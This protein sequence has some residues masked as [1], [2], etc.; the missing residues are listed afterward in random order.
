MAKEFTRSFEVRWSE[1]GAANRVPASKYMEYLVETAYD[2][3]AENRLGFEE[4]QILGLVWLILETDIH[5]LHP[6]RFGD[7]FDFTIWMLDWR[8]ISGTRAFELR[9]KDS[10]KIVAHGMQ[11][12]VSLDDESLRPKAV[13]VE[14]I[15]G[16]RMEA[17][18]SFDSQRFPKLDESPKE[19]FRIQRRVE[20]GELDSLVHLNNGE[21]LR[22]VDEVLMQF[23]ASLGWPPER[24]K[25]EGLVPVAKGV[26]I[27]YQEV[28]L[29]ADK[30]TVETVPLEVQANEVSSAIVVTRES[31]AK[32]IF[33]AIYRWGIVDLKNDEERVLP[34]ELQAALSSLI[35]K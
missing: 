19:T 18:R 27:K 32:S 34:Q 2:W 22:Y 6:L 3:G 10:G 4:S 25:A 8:K 28:G 24:L 15:D 7:E 35:K 11:K 5:F 21:A 17:P 20:W 26:H 1:V 31:D 12:I 29:W 33:Q 13:P 9:L 23:L 14:I 16:F 30:L